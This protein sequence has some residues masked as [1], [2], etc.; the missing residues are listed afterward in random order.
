MVTANDCEGRSNDTPP[1]YST[2]SRAMIARLTS[3]LSDEMRSSC[4]GVEWFRSGIGLHDCFF[5]VSVVS[6]FGLHDL[7]NSPHRFRACRALHL[8]F[9]G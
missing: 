5:S 7:L 2:L 3:Q 9:S 4:S 8:N 6:S 1:C